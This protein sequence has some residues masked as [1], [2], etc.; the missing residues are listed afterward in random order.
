[1]PSQFQEDLWIEEN[2]KLPAKGFYLDVGCAFPDAC[3]NTQFLRNKGWQGLAIDA[4][5]G[6]AKY[7][8][9]HFMVGIVSTQPVVLMDF[10]ETCTHSRIGDKGVHHAATTLDNLCDGLGIEQIDLISLDVEG[11]EYD[12]LRSLDLRRFMPQV[13]VSEFDTD[14]IGKDWRVRD[15]LLANGYELGHQTESNIIMLR[16]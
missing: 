4:N 10:R 6:Y 15:Y 14:G 8:P 11:G 7:W 3:S 5:P 1:M 13:I 16:K 9:A 2:V 12:A